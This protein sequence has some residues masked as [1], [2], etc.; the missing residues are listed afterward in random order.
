MT[1]ENKQAESTA[2]VAVPDERESYINWMTGSYPRVYSKSEAEHY[3]RNEHVSALAW[4]ARA[5]LAKHKEV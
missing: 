1:S 5:A 4:Q 3:W 2:A